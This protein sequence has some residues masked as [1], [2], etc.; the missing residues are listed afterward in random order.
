MSINSIL[1]LS[2]GSVQVVCTTGASEDILIE[3]NTIE[4]TSDL[5]TGVVFDL[6]G[7]QG[8][9]SVTMV[10]NTFN[11]C[12]CGIFFNN[13]GVA[14][15]YSD[16][17]IG[18]NTFIDRN[19][20]F[21]I[22]SDYQK[23]G[24]YAKNISTKS[25]WSIIG[26][27][28][29][30]FNPINTNTVGGV[31]TRN[32]VYIAGGNNY[33]FVFKANRVLNVGDGFFPMASTGA[34]R[35]GAAINSVFDSNTI[36]ACYGTYA[37][38]IFCDAQFDDC[39]ISNNVIKD[40]QGSTASLLAAGG[41]S[42]LKFFRTSITGNTFRDVRNI[43]G[44]IAGNIIVADTA[45][46][47]FD[48]CTVTG[49]TFFGT[50]ATYSRLTFGVCLYTNRLSYCTISNNTISGYSCGNIFVTSTTGGYI[51][52]T[53]ISGNTSKDCNGLLGT[54]GCIWVA[55]NGAGMRTNT[56]N[57]NTSL[58]PLPGVLVS[59]SYFGLTINDNS[60][61]NT[62]NNPAIYVDASQNFTIN[63]NSC[64]RA[65]GS[66]STIIV[67]SSSNLFVI[68][69]NRCRDGS[70]TGNSINTW[71]SGATK[72]IVIGNVFT[73]PVTFSGGTT[74]AHNVQE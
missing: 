25:R 34:F 33:E 47:E 15:L 66:S 3:G 12:E 21:G 28:F 61:E 50:D 36:V 43:G 67:N 9:R 26:N 58:A 57:G 38:G 51:E 13:S 46:G 8:I 23:V 10:N 53:T 27:N 18:G 52:Q 37:H 74:D 68:S 56:I 6:A 31:V 2:F 30:N 1:S 42:A 69:G 60:A 44:G 49:N 32:A 35:M 55:G 62:S 64:A 70:A 24:I 22:V 59:G 7:G 19:S 65:S 39:T 29:T 54:G 41:I 48:T 73:A 71:G 16:I 4:C 11:K 40:V 14:A 5:G 17:N 72:A 45:A 63:G 20:L